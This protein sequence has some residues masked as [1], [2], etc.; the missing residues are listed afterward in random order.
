MFDN[1]GAKIMKLAKILCWIGIILSIISGIIIIAGGA[2][3]S[4]AYGYDGG[5]AA[6]TGILT[7]VLGCLA[8]WIGSF[9]TY[10]FGQL[11]ENTDNIRYNTQRK[12]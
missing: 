8:S 2:S 6:L 12:E 11:I 4:R 3:N 5:S 10:G 7:I 1:I 9:F